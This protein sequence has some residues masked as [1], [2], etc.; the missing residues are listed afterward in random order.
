ML[1]FFSWV[2]Y[3]VEIRCNFSDCLLYFFYNRRVGR[4]DFDV[5]GNYFGVEILVVVENGFYV[6]SFV[7]SWVW[8]VDYGKGYGIFIVVS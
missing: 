5:I 1:V 7:E 8:N 2:S 4:G 3:D 6:Y